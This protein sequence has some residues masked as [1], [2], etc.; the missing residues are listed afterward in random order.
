MRALVIPGAA[1]YSRSE[2]DALVDQA[3][4]LGRRRHHVG[5]QGRRRHQHERQGGG[6]GQ[7]PG[8]HGG[9]RVR[10]QDLILLAGGKPDDASKLLGAFR[11]SLAKKENLIPAD[12]FEFAWVVDFPLFDWD[13]EDKRWV[14]MHHPFTAPLDEDS[15]D[16]RQRPVEGARQGLRPRAERQRDRR[17]QH[18]YPRLRRC[19]AGSSSC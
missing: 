15:R 5:A 11:L 13:A 4:Q 3:K 8:E 12:R 14:P 2:L 17:R 7:A 16:A 10:R 18:P 1:R 9:G 6:R 19:R